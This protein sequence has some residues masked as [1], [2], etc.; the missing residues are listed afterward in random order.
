MRG[1]GNHFICL[2]DP[3]PRKK[4]AH[5]SQTMMLCAHTVVPLGHCHSLTHL[6]TSPWLSSGGV[7]HSLGIVKDVAETNFMPWGC[8]CV[9]WC[10]VSN[11]I[12]TTALQAGWVEA[13]SSCLGTEFLPF[14]DP[15]TPW[16]LWAIPSYA[17]MDQVSSGL[18]P[19]LLQSSPAAFTHV[20]VQFHCF[21]WTQVEELLHLVTKLS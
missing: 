2:S 15:R 5:Q 9:S 12:P 21:R 7:P 20:R 17:L 14:M 16:Q 18:F 13:S 1:G 6:M 10:D 11:T 4:E 8:P 3:I 19:A